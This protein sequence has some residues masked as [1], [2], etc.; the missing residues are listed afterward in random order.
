MYLRPGSMAFKRS[1]VRSRLSP[2]IQGKVLGKNSLK[3]RF[4]AVFTNNPE[5]ASNRCK[6][7]IA[8]CILR[9]KVRKKA[10]V[11]PAFS[12]AAGSGFETGTG[13]ERKK[14][15]KPA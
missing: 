4:Q 7:D 1:A 12:R 15:R 6:S 10:G 5:N 3:L 11:T 8:T 9:V 14:P 2:P 13:L